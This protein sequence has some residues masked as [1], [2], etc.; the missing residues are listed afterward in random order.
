M[1]L[2]ILFYFIGFFQDIDIGAELIAK[3]LAVPEEKH[4]TVK[5][6]QESSSKKNVKEQI[7]A[8][9]VNGKFNS[10]VNNLNSSTDDSSSG[11]I[12]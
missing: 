2:C 4:E 12:G 8:K 7:S 6:K 1:L 9:E 10:S 11:D 3:G 5:T